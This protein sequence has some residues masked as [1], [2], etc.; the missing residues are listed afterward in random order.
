MSKSLG[1]VVVPQDVLSKYGVDA[2]RF[3]VSHEIPVGS[4]GDFSWKRIDELYD[5]KLRNNLGNLLNRVLV[6]LKKDGG[7]LG[8]FGKPDFLSPRQQEFTDLMNEFR[9]SEALAIAMQISDE[10]NKH[11]DVT[12]PWTLKGQEKIDVLTQLAEALRH[13]SLALLSFIPETAQKIS[14]QLGVPYA[15]EMLNHDFVITKEMKAWGG[16][17]N[18]KTVG[19]PAILFAPLEEKPAK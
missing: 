10:S 8:S 9:F 16:I 18:W 5:A 13:V 15:S 7:T 4:D 6:L 11:I 19:E 12:K 2:L 3:Y 14:V 1:N 17:K